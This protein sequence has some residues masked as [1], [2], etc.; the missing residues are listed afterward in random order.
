MIK[1]NANDSV[2]VTLEP[3]GNI[4]KGHKIATADIAKG[5]PVIKYGFPIGI[6]T[7]DI[8]AGAHVHT[9]NLKSAISEEA[10]YKYKPITTQKQPKQNGIFKGFLRTNGKVGIR[11]EI[12]IVNTVG[13][14]NKASE[15]IAAKANE[16]YKDNSDGIFTAMHPFGCSQLGED[17]EN[18]RQLLA[19]T[20]MHPNAAGVLVLGLGCENN[21]ICSFKKLLGN[22]DEK[23]VKF[24]LTQDCENEIEAGV[25]LIG[26]IVNEIQNDTRVNT[27]IGSLIIGLKCGG[28]DAFS[29]ITANPLVGKISDRLISFGGTAVL[30]ETPEMFGAETILMGRCKSEADFKKTSDMINNF[31]RYFRNH[32]QNVYENPSPGNKAGGITTLEEKSLGCMQKGG[33]GEITEVIGY[34]ESVSKKGLVLLDGPG[35][36]IVSTTAMTATGCHIILFTTGCGTPLGALA[37][38]IK[39]SS[40]SELAKRKSNWIDYNA[41]DLLAGKCINQATDEL[42][43]LI[44]NIAEGKE[45]KSEINDYR[46][47]AIFKTGVT[48]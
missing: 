4:P 43:D 48:L 33:T 17:H 29:G 24:L 34:G 32:G 9:H 19:G 25:K 6:A 27:D 39:I 36:D 40:N 26:E 5:E 10:E 44:I 30:T 15:K 14:V 7:T 28:S 46:E 45:T 16:L 18:T 42:W 2:M 8:K 35:N 21:S 22:Y 11:N 41:G 23:R 31:K 1:L 12:W 13:C 38:T 47:F 37:P 20:A 3:I